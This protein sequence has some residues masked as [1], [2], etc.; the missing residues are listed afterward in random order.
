MPFTSL[1]LF[2]PNMWDPHF[3]KQIGFLIRIECQMDVKL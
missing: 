3:I 2:H 1:I